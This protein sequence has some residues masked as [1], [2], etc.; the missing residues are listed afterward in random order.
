MRIDRAG[1]RTC[2][3]MRSSRSLGVIDML[4]KC[5]IAF[6]MGMRIGHRSLDLTWT[7]P[8]ICPLETAWNV[9][10]EVDYF[11]HF[12][13]HSFLFFF[14]GFLFFLRRDNLRRFQN[15]KDIPRFILLFFS[16]CSLWYLCRMITWHVQ[17]EEEEDGNGKASK[18]RNESRFTPISFVWFLRLLL[19]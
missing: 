7:W 12:I 10:A 3:I 14:S 16:L 19:P 13:F 17:R 6:D 1:K 8:T 5:R 11:V 15:E 9:Y 18:V 2:W 4:F